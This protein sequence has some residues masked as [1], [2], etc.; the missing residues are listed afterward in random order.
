MEQNQS[1]LPS[2]VWLTC[3]ARSIHVKRRFFDE[4]CIDD[5]EIDNPSSLLRELK[6]LGQEKMY[7][8]DAAALI[9]L[10]T[11]NHPEP[12]SWRA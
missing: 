1:H 4:L 8:V 6:L 2:E 7:A 5:A 3:G 12:L 10:I 9:R 11:E